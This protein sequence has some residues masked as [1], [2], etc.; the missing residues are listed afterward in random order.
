MRRG[1]VVVAVVATITMLVWGTG[2]TATTPARSR[3]E[4]KPTISTPPRPRQTPVER[5]LA[6]A[7]PTTG[8]LSKRDAL[9]L[10]A[11]VFG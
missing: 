2:A 3:P 7:S 1:F 11:T 6:K 8:Q 5:L 9:T 10:F 4:P